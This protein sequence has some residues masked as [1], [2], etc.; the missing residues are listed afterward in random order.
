MEIYNTICPN[1]P[2]L[3]NNI[4]LWRPTKNNKRINDDD[5]EVVKCA[6]IHNYLE[7]QKSCHCRNLELGVHNGGFITTNWNE[8]SL[9]HNH[10]SLLQKYNM[11]GCGRYSPPI[12]ICLLFPWG[13]GNLQKIKQTFHVSWACHALAN[14]KLPQI[15]HF[16]SFLLS[17]H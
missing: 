14:G 12:G 3:V 8:S 9:L 16:V 4:K 5:N 10:G 13:V 1:A 17:F 2:N 6:S 7:I 15:E 11:Y